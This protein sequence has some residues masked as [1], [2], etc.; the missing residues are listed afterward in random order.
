MNQYVRQARYKKGLLITLEFPP[1]IGGVSS[2]LSEL[3][4]GVPHG[5]LIVL[6]P[7]DADIVYPHSVIREDLYYQNFW[8]KWLKTVKLTFSLLRRERISNIMISHVLPMGYV[9]LL[10]KLIFRIPY[11]IFFHGMDVRLS[12]ANKWKKFWFKR[13]VFGAEHIVA[14]SEFTKNEILKLVSTARLNI[15]VIAP[16]PKIMSVGKSTKDQARI[17][18]VSRL[19][20]RKGI[21]LGIAAFLRIKAELP[22]A[23]YYIAGDGPER[24]RL[25]KQIQNL[26]LKDSV[27]MLGAVPD[28]TLAELYS[29]A[30]LFLF[31]V[32]EL[33]GADV[34][35]F[36]IAPLE[37]SAHGVPVV[38]ARTGGVAEAV[39]HGETGILVPPGNIEALAQ[40]SIFVLKNPEIAR[41]MG[42]AGRKWGAGFSAPSQTRK[43][44]S[45]IWPEYR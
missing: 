43:L 29:R 22:E 33:V 10:A 1:T 23:Q 36:G 25:E 41:A 37:A 30:T 31:P 3:L 18:S 27:H 15:K 4:R 16:S 6:A 13:I 7:K 21:D 8:P 19:V 34:E 44:I 42:E 40:A 9:A 35:G 32:R 20:A 12:A 5:S 14:N 26:N 39:V 28:A 2:Y 45:I 24:S 11:T 38:A 17:L